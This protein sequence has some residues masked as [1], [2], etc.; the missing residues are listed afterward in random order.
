MSFFLLL[1]VLALVAANVY[2]VLA[3]RATRAQLELAK[4]GKKEAE[5]ALEQDRLSCIC[6]G[7][8]A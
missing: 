6:R 3:L 4:Q 7:L 5:K 8:E 2:V 1:M